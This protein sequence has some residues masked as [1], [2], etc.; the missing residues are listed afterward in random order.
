MICVF[1][2]NLTTEDLHKML[3]KVQQC[4]IPPPQYL[5]VPYSQ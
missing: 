5:S 4:R 1:I 2:S 3:Y